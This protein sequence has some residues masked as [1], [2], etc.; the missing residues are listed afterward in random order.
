MKT[1]QI[2]LLSVEFVFWIRSR[3]FCMFAFFVD[4]KSI[5]LLFDSKQLDDVN[6]TEARILDIPDVEGRKGSLEYFVSCR[7]SSDN[8]FIVDREFGACRFPFMN[9]F[10]I[11]ALHRNGKFVILC[12]HRKR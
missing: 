11:A 3:I 8:N 12:Y 9:I 5:G 6:G 2:Y 4:L 10:T 7:L 1:K